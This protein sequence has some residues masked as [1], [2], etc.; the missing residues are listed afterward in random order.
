MTIIDPLYGQERVKALL[1][2]SFNESK[3]R[4]ASVSLRMFASRLGV[5]APIVSEVLN[6]KRLITKKLAE[7]ILSGLK[8]D[9]I[10]VEALLVHFASK[11]VRDSKANKEILDASSFRLVSDWWYM[12][13]LSLAETDSCEASSL[14]LS[15]RFNIS[16]TCAAEAVSTLCRLGFAKK[17][18]NV[19]R[20]SGKYIRFASSIPDESIKK[21]HNQGLE[22]A[23]K[24]L[25]QIDMELR[26][27]GSVTFKADPELLDLARKK[28]RN[29]RNE[30]AT[31]MNNKN[32]SEVYR[33]Q[34]QL[35]P[36]TNKKED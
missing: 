8:I 24:A 27:F 4:N 10:E 2:S 20:S 15:K 29:V 25:Y 36:L 3:S 16:E 1:T 13:I 14:W 11:Q 5:Q 32:A 12:A 26:E 31:L 7:K 34:V 17:E 28:L 33:L 19:L 23:Q 6:G 18:K 35:Y 9:P 30:I 22:L 21:H